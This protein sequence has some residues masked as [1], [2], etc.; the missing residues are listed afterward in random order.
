[1]YVALVLSGDFVI[2]F[3]LTVEQIKYLR[4]PEEILEVVRD[5][6]QNQPSN[7]GGRGRGD[8]KDRGRGGRGGRGRGRGRGG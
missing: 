8:G 1:M 6:Q 2:G 3:R 5:Q 7:R 4:V